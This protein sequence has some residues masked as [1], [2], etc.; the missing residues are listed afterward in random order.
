MQILC[1]TLR[2]SD[3]IKTD[4]SLMKN[5]EDFDFQVTLHCDKFL[6]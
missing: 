1:I 5:F 4:D 6:Q 3:Y 2:I